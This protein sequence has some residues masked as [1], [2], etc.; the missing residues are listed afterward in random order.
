MV[1]LTEVKLDSH[2]GLVLDWA[3]ARSQDHQLYG[4]A[5]INGNATVVM[6]DIFSA[7]GVVHLISRPLLQCI[8]VI[9]VTHHLEHA[10]VED[11]NAR[12]KIHNSVV[13]VEMKAHL[14]RYC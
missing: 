13:H 14:L 2:A 3:G 4:I 1:N 9:M 6:G 11:T 10:N 8:R 7:S 12:F 5:I